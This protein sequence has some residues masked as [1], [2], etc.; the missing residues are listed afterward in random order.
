[1]K[2]FE[3]ELSASSLKNLIKDL[4]KYQKD[5]DNSLK[6]INEAIADEVYKL[7]MQ[8]VPDL[9]GDLKASVQKE[10]T[11]EYA[12]VFT[13]NEHSEFA[14]FG[15]GIVGSNNPHPE[16]SSQ[17]WTYDVNNHGEKGWVYKGKNG[18]TY[19]TKG[20]TGRKYMYKSYIEIQKELIPIAERVLKQRGLI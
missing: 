3:A 17:G 12:R 6:H 8:Y 14:E 15:T 19:R 16:A 7:V 2:T 5:L 10:V 18:I 9:T 1:M 20:Y 11:Q 13:D 4:N